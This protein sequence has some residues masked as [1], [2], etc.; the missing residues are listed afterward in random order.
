MLVLLISQSPLVKPKIDIGQIHPRPV[1]V[2]AKVEETVV[3][4]QGVPAEPVEYA[5]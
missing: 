4:V 1:L 5:Y 2:K 3:G